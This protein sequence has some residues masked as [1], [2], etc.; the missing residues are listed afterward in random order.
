MEIQ[1]KKF[2]LETDPDKIAVAYDFDP[3]KIADAVQRGTV[4]LMSAV[5]AKIAIENARKKVTAEGNQKITSVAED[6]LN[7]QPAPQGMPQGMPQMQLAQQG[8]GG[9]PV[10]APKM[11][12]GVNMGMPQPRM[13]AQMPQGMGATPQ[14]AQMQA[15][16]QKNGSSS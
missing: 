11:P 13:S 9:A 7:P 2:A 4:D 10:P 5:L 14:A 8:L 1:Q 12:A 15:M 3:K 16:Q 6:T